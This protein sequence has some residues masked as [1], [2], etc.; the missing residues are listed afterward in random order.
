MLV[1]KQDPNFDLYTGFDVQIV[2]KPGD[3]DSRLIVDDGKYEPD[4]NTVE[5]SDDEE[6]ET[7][8]EIEEELEEE[9]EPE[10]EPDLTYPEYPLPELED[11]CPVIP[12]S[13]SAEYD[14][15]EVHYGLRDA[16]FYFADA[17]NDG[18]STLNEMTIYTDKLD[19][20]WDS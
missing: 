17:N 6:E 2:I 5:N 13:Y 7:E 14:F 12:E 8:E 1:K 4:P 16:I 10:P 3:R 11:G 15:C 19:H 18:Y 20:D 9:P